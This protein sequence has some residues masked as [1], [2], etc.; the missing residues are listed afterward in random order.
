ME[1]LGILE[2]KINHLLETIS[3][4][5]DEKNSLVQENSELL[6]KIEQMESH[7]SEGRQELD[8]EKERAKSF[9]DGLIQSIDSLVEL[10][11]SDG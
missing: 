10:E 4:L 7:L 9:V 1:A 8:A 5:K 2:K 6:L 11:N 3:K